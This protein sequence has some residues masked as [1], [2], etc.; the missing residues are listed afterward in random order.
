M[1]WSRRKERQESRVERAR[2][3]RL[4]GFAR[5]TPAWGRT[6]EPEV[7]RKILE[8]LGLPTRGPPLAAPMGASV[9][10]DHETWHEEPLWDF[11]Q[12][13]AAGG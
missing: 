1:Q 5:S 13:P 4:A 9:D 3:G 8:C 11:N 12:A 2:P 10:F 6:R 7:A